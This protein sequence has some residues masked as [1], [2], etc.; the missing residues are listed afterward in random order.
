LVGIPELSAEEVARRSMEIA[1]NMC[2]Y[3]NT[4]FR[5]EIIDSKVVEEKEVEESS[6]TDAE[7]KE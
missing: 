4:N 7:K 6:S 3:T 2:V 5:S 1:A